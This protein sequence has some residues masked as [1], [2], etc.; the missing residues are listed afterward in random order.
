MNGLGDTATVAVAY[1][2]HQ[3]EAKCQAQSSLEEKKVKERLENRV[4]SEIKGKQT[5][6]L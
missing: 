1:L 6:P 4:A 3:L 2:C 5:L